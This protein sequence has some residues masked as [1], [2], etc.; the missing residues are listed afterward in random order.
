[1]G[2]FSIRA[3]TNGTPAPT[4]YSVLD[5][6]MIVH[7]DV[8]TDGQ[9]RVDGR[10]EGS[11]LRSDGVV[12]GIGATVVGDVS[13]REIII[14]GSVTGNVSATGRVELQAT[15]AVAGD[16][17]SSAIMI[18]EGGLIQGR[19]SIHPISAEERRAGALAAPSVPRLHAYSGGAA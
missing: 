11:I 1:M 2:L 6:Q 15:G 8:E 12:I 18:Q 3:N 13:G 7:G 9:L 19:L 4:G 5:T 16:I 14:G 17:E 10:L